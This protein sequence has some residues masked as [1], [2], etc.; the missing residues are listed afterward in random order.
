M[1]IRLAH[2]LTRVEG[3]SELIITQKQDSQ[4]DVTYRLPN[5]RDFQNILIGQYIEDLPKIVPRICG[6]CPIAHRIGAVKALEV[7]FDISPPHIAE[8]IRELAFL[9]E[10]IRSHTY[11]VFFS[12]LPDLMH[13]SNQVSRQDIIGVDKTQSRALPVATKLYRA[14]E[15]LV[16]K[17]AGNTNMANN[18]IIGGVRQNLTFDQQQDLIQTLHTLL[19]DIKWAKEFYHWLLNEVEGEIKPFILPKPL[20]ISSFD[21]TH[22]WFSG[23]N[24]VTLFSEEKLIQSFPCREFPQQLQEKTE[25]EF[26][27]S[28]TYTSVHHPT[29]RLLAGPHARLA[30]LHNKTAHKNQP[31]IGV[32]NLFYAGLLRLDEIEFSITNALRL[33]ESDW[34]I[35]N[36]VTITWQYQPGAGASA[37][38]APRG[39][40]LYHLEVNEQ[41]T[42]KN[43]QIIV[44]TEINILAL[45]EIT[46]N[47][48]SVCL[49]LGWSIDQTMERAQMGIRCF[50]PCVSCATHTDIKFRE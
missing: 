10:V 46:K 29:R 1:K 27:T 17:T 34:N 5:T 19:P 13:L 35:G 43:L 16:T 21:T 3:D 18:L 4:V 12:T 32:P 23:S 22:N 6:I 37:V 38:E 28:V 14:A 40:L 49:E 30:A 25:S 15:E 8:I 33:L 2:P 36:D 31:L 45:T 41:Q 47:I 39:T 50:D 9:G 20:F 11:S 48:V 24:E 44:P 7:T 26:P 42:I